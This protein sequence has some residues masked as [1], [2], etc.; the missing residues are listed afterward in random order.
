MICIKCGREI[1]RSYGAPTLAGCYCLSCALVNGL[2]Q[3]QI[4]EAAYRELAKR[5]QYHTVHKMYS[6]L[7]DEFLAVARCQKADEPNMKSQEVFEIL[8]RVK[9]KMSEGI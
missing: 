3:P 8:S 7:Y 5:V 1:D 6:L 4:E 2:T 9:R